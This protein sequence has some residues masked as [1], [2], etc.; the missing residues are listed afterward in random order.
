MKDSE[1]I[2]ILRPC[3]SSYCECSTNECSNARYYD[4][5]F[6][7]TSFTESILMYPTETEV[8]SN[9]P[10]DKFYM[11]FVEGCNSP[12]KQ[13]ST[14]QSAQDE[15]RRLSEKHVNKKV[16]ILTSIEYLKTELKP[17]VRCVVNA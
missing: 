13:H 8:S 3:K 6:P 5:R 11:I 9:N 1:K 14:F 10:K 12:A 16:F 7:G 4:A 15:A 2:G 17:I